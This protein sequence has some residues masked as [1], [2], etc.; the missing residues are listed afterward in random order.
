MTRVDIRVNNCNRKKIF[1][2]FA[3]CNYMSSSVVS[4][5]FV[6]VVKAY[7]QI[8]CGQQYVMKLVAA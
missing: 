6:M 8:C 7:V 3:L 2:N 4:R 5:V 1:V